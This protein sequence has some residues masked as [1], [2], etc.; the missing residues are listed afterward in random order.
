MPAVSASHAVQFWGDFFELDWRRLSTALARKD[1]CRIGQAGRDGADTAVYVNA[2]QTRL[3][4]G[5]GF[6]Q[7]AWGNPAETSP[8]RELILRHQR[9]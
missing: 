9:C 2:R 4:A 3:F 7:A 5:P 8:I 6:C 1:C